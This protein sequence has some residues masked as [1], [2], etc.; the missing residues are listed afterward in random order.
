MLFLS[1]FDVNYW[2]TLAFYCQRPEETGYM[3]S[4]FDR[5][6]LLALVPLLTELGRPDGGRS[7]LAIPT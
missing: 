6:Y 2:L 7:E 1:V 4:M 5:Y 3:N